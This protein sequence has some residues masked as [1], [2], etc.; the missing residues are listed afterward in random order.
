MPAPEVLS[1][2]ELLTFVRDLQAGQALRVQDDKKRKMFEGI[3]RRAARICR[4]MNEATAADYR[5]WLRDDVLRRK[6]N[7][8][9]R[10]FLSPED[11]GKTYT[12]TSHSFLELVMRIARE[13]SE[14]TKKG[15]QN[16]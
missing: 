14:F 5:E 3:A 12:L 8:A 16:V 6:K 7:D 11:D 2:A 13:F 10:R 15:P 4:R 9:V 1:T